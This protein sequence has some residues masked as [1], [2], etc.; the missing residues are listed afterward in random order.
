M[1][2]LRGWEK[3]ASEREIVPS[4]SRI[5]SGKSYRGVIRG[6]VASVFSARRKLTAG[7]SIYVRFSQIRIHKVQ[8]E[9]RDQ[10]LYLG[11]CLS[12]LDVVYDLKKI[13]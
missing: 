5:S 4:I 10:L 7:H 3:S 6:L 8:C 2:L 1:G 13:V 11:C 12:R 9:K